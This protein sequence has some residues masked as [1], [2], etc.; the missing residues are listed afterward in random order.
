MARESNVRVKRDGKTEALL[1]RPLRE[2]DGQ[3]VVR[4]KGRLWPV[5]N[6]SIEIGAGATGLS[7]PNP[8]NESDNRSGAETHAESAA[9]HSSGTTAPGLAP[10]HNDPVR[11][12]PN[13]RIVVDAGPGTGKTYSACNRVAM[14]VNEGIPPTRICL[15][16]F[17]RTAVVEIRNRIASALADP[18]DAA[19][20]RIVTL[21]SY[22]WAVQSGFSQDAKLTG[23]F[24]DNIASALALIQNDPEVRDEISRLE[25]L[26]VD[27]AQ[28]IVGPRAD[29][30]L[31]M[32]DAIEPGNGITV[33]AD[34]AQAIYGWSE[35]SAQGDGTKLLEELDKRGFEQLALTQVYRTSDQRLLEIATGLRKDLLLGNRSN[36]EQH[37][38]SEIR[39]L[40]HEDAGDSKQ[41]DL[42]GLP[43]DAL[44][45]MR[46]RLEV[47]IA[48]SRAGLLPHRLRM[49]GLPHCIMPCFAQVLWDFTHRVI[50]IDEFHRRWEERQIQASI[51]C[52]DAWR[53]CVEFAGESARVVDLYR[54]RTVLSRSSPP[55]L[56]CSPEF[57]NSGPIL[58]TIHASKGREAP[59]VYL[60]LPERTNPDES[61]E[62]SRVMF[63]GATRP[64]VRLLVGT[65]GAHLGASTNG[66]SWRRAGKGLQIEI[67]R[68]H[69]IDPTCMV[70]RAI[71]SRQDH[72]MDAQQAWLDRPNRLSMTARAEGPLKWRFALS[73]GELRLA[74]FTDEFRSDMNKIGNSVQRQINWIGHV[75]SIGIRTMAIGPDSH[76]LE[77]LLEPWRSSGFCVAPLISTLGYVPF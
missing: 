1:K 76:H 29:L 31:A 52:E 4:F 39:R 42:S 35:D 20:V 46:N 41:L 26:I 22:A 69:D 73:Q 63:V 70:G 49:S 37:V 44:V 75:R 45:L 12:P 2:I 71:F 11:R 3:L 18:F 74:G 32:I 17:T 58:G 50:S 33:F 48:S 60:Y 21:D 13:A 40:A 23:K 25:H 55:M 56:F 59:V 28:D 62:E 5:V 64:R 14:L 43:S 53:R 65:S 8:L 27:E 7:P 15:L 19:S 36:L 66:R 34:R 57:G 68:T 61:G 77:E 47:L 10:A 51:S 16:S 24:D 9:V 54:L 72:A 38:K 67:G 6:G 30:V